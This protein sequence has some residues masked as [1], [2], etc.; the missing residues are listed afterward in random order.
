MIKDIQD[1]DK[2]IRKRKMI[3]KY[4]QTR[5]VPEKIINK[6]IDN[7]CRAPSAG[8]TQVQE[9]IVIKDPIIKRKLRLAS[10]NQEQVEKA[11]VLITVCSNISRSVGRYRERGK[12]FYSI[13]DGSFASMLILLTATN[14]GLGA[15]FVG[16][17]NDEQ[18][19]EILGLPEHVRP[20]GIIALGYPS[21]NP[22]KLER[23]QRE[24]LVH[25]ERW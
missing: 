10:V 5:Q 8:H 22:A 18:V 17:F 7:A 14:E 12:E 25:Y 15:S 19:S 2:V 6:L 3:R 21:E 13:I 9:F 23:I 11:P 1:L 16:A 20:I 24:R 4:D